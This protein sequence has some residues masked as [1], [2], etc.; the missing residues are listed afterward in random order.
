MALTLCTARSRNSARGGRRRR[1][2]SCPL[3]APTRAACNPTTT[4]PLHGPLAPPS[5]AP[6]R[7]CTAL[8]LCT[9]RSRKNDQQ[10]RCGVRRAA[11]VELRLR[12][13]DRRGAMRTAA[14]S[15]VADA[16]ADAADVGAAAA[17]A[18]AAASGRRGT[19]VCFAGGLLDGGRCCGECRAQQQRLAVQVRVAAAGMAAAA[20]VAAVG[21]SIHGTAVAAALERVAAAVAASAGAVAA[22]AGA[23]AAAT[24]T[25]VGVHGGAGS[26]AFA[27]RAAKC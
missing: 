15:A 8:A 17:A 9:A 4:C 6:A 1:R 13:A 23:V 25:G 11:A 19:L 20:A 3:S 26:A 7:T 18:A 10:A 27:P 16:P 5:S 22:S 24:A 12:H 21:I 14:A 2:P